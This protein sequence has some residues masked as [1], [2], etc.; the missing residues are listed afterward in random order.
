MPKFPVIAAAAAS[1]L[2]LTGLA[3]AANAAPHRL[4]LGVAGL[5]VPVGDEENAEVQNL[6]E[7]ETDRG[8]PRD[9]TGPRVAEPPAGGESAEDALESTVGDDGINAIQRES[10]PPEK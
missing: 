5:L 9:E 3:S 6:I 7:P 10:I 1:A 2:I 4:S 8:K